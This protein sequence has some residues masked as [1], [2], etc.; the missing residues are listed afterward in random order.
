MIVSDLTTYLL[1]IYPPHGLL[2][3]EQ[4]MA[5]VDMNGISRTELGS[6]SCF[7][8]AFPFMYRDVVY[9]L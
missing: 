6:K 8:D 9:S 2:C 4:R 3:L 7:H 1:T 5:L